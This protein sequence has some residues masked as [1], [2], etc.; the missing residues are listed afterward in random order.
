MFTYNADFIVFFFASTNFYFIENFYCNKY[1][2]YR[3][4]NA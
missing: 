3:V 2:A 1:Y 4:L